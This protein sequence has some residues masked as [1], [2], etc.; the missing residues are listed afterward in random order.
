M[1]SRPSSVSDQLKLGTTVL[2]FST[3]ATSAPWVFKMPFA[4]GAGAETS[5]ISG[6]PGLP[7]G[8]T[9]GTSAAAREGAG[10]ERRAVGTLTVRGASLPLAAM[11][12]VP[13][14][15][16]SCRPYCVSMRWNASSG[17]GGRAETGAAAGEDQTG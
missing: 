2:T 9:R 11:L 13:I 5:S 7:A 17:G 10:E 15:R 4:A 12:G 8:F 14:W 3:L 16:E 6:L 1:R